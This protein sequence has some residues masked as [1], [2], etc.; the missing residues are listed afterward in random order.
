MKWNVTLKTFAFLLTAVVAMPLI[1]STP[2]SAFKPVKNGNGKPHTSP[3]AQPALA[4]H[5]S[6]SP[7]KEMTEGATPIGTTPI[8][9]PNLAPRISEQR[10]PQPSPELPGIGNQTVFAPIPQ[11]ADQPVVLPIFIQE[12]P[13]HQENPNVVPSDAEQESPESGFPKTYLSPTNARHKMQHQPVLVGGDDGDS[14]SIAAASQFVAGSVSSQHTLVA[15]AVQAKARA[16]LMRKSQQ[17]QRQQPEIN[18]GEGQLITS[19]VGKPSG[20]SELEVP[21]PVLVADPA[22]QRGNKQD[23]DNLARVNAE[24]NFA[25]ELNKLKREYIKLMKNPHGLINEAQTA[26]KPVKELIK[27]LFNLN[28]KKII[29]RYPKKHNEKLEI[30]LWQEIENEA[31]KESSSCCPSCVIQ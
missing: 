25:K 2:L 21:E 22:S 10:Q 1:A 3:K 18:A 8:V 9:S 4:P 19:A 16:S 17:G 30:K 31:S 14:A 13:S 26:K 7:V 28:Y 20:F 11:V 6:L 27:S 29:S 5:T 15:P 24:L 12:V 23:E